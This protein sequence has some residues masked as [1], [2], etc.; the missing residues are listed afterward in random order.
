MNYPEYTKIDL[1]CSQMPKAAQND[2]KSCFEATFTFY[3]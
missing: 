3:T 2:V 1:V